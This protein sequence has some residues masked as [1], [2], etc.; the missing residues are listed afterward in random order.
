MEGLKLIPYIF[1]VIC[2]AGIIGGAA[3][4]TMGKF[5]GTMTAC[6]NSSYAL[7]TTTYDHCDNN[8]VGVSMS[9]SVGPSNTNLSDEYYTKV[10]SQEGITTIAEQIPTVA[11]IAVMVIIISVI[12]GVFVYMRYFA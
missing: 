10:Q 11:I 2:I 6:Y 12:A 9:E 7:N 8:S 5:G 4:V 1:L 3:A